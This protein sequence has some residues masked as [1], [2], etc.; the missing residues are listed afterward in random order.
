MA[1][2]GI[3][4]ALEYARLAMGFA[5]VRA[6]RYGIRYSGGYSSTET[7]GII[8][9]GGKKCFLHAGAGMQYNG[10][11][12]SVLLGAQR[13][14]PRATPYAYFLVCPR[15]L[16]VSLVERYPIWEVCGVLL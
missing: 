9:D 12:N 1:K 5:S 7:G 4:R 14:S 3:K 8:A 15:T 16:A 13:A 6:S 10:D 2:R 11:D